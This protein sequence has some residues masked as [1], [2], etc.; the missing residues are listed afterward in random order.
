[1]GFNSY[2]LKNQKLGETEIRGFGLAQ[3]IDRKGSSP[4]LDPDLSLY[5]SAQQY[6][7]VFKMLD[8]VLAYSTET[9]KLQSSATLQSLCHC[10][11][12]G[13]ALSVESP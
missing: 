4:M 9:P 11:C 1:M 10:H 5:L 3:N 6:L 13:V 8:S 2:F 7:V 12:A